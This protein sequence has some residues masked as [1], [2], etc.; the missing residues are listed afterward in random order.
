[1][2]KRL[3]Y[4]FLMLFVIL[5]G[6]MRA[7]ALEQDVNGVYQIGTAQDLIDFAAVV[8]DGEFGANAV[9]TTDIALSE[10]W[11]TP[12]GGGTGNAAPG[13]TAYT[14]IFDGQGHSITGFNAEGN[15]HLGLFGDANGATIKN[16]SISGTL[17]QTGGYGGGVVAWPAN[18][19]IENVHSALVINVP[20]GSTH[21]VGGVVGSARGGNTISGCT[22]S[23]SMIVAAS[24]TDNF[25][26]VVAYLGGDSVVFCANYG[27]ITFDDSGCAAGG[28]A[29]Y[30]NN[31]D[32]YVMGCLNMG[33]VVYNDLDAT[34]ATPKWGGAIVGRLRNHDLNKVKNNIW[35]EGSAT[36]AGKDNDG[37]VNLT[38]ALCVTQEQFA[39]GELCYFLNGDQSAIGWYQT[40]GT[41][42]IPV[43]DA[44]HAQV[45]MNGRLHCNG[46][47]Y[48]GAT[49]SNQ[50]TDII[51]DEHDFVDG[52]CS[53][54]GFFNESFLIPNADGYYE[55]ANARQLVWFEQLV[56]NGKVDANAVLKADI[57]F[58]DL[59]TEEEKEDPEQAEIAWTPIGDWHTGAVSSA[60]QGHF[61]GQGHTI[62]HFNVTSTQNY[63]GVFGVVST[64]S[65][66]ENFD[67]YGT[68][69]LGHKTGAVVAYT[70]D[71]TC[72]I[73]NIH[74]YMTLNIT[75]ATVTAERP[76]GIVGS[77]VN[78]TTI[79]ENCT[80][81]GILNVGGHTGN[82]G[83]I[84]GYINNN[85]AAIVNITNCLFD[86]EIQNG[87]SADGQCG[88]IVG[89]NNGG[90]AT[91]KNCLSVGTIVSSEG[92]IG[93]LI[94]RLNGSNTVFANNYYVGEFVNGTK[95]GKSAGGTAPVNVDNGQLASGEICWKLNEETFID[96]VWHQT[97]GENDYP[98]LN[99]N[100]AI[101]YQTPSG[102][103]CVSEKNPDSFDSFRD[104]IIDKETDFI[105]D[106]NMVAY[107][108][109][110]DEYKETIKSWEEID[111]YDDF[112]AAYK[113]I[114]ELKERVMTSAASYAAYV[115]ACEYAVTYLEENNVEGEWATLLQTYLQEDNSVEPDNDYPN[116]SYA[117]IMENR[118]LD[119]DAI[120]A[121]IAFVNQM[122]ENAIAGGITAGTEITRLLANSTFTQGEDNFEGWSKE[123]DGTIAF[124]TGG[125]TELMPL[126]RALGNGT[127]NISQTLTELPNGIYM[128]A[129]NGLFRS[130][131]DVTHQF[132]AGQLYL[133]GTANYF[134]SPGEDVVLEEDAVPGENCL[135]EGSDA[136]FNDKDGYMIG[137][138]PKSLK[139]CSY[140]YKAG[141]YQ[142]FCATEVTDGNLTVGVRSLG[143]GLAS[144]W[145]PF[146]NLHVYY[147]GTAEEANEKL[148]D[149]LEAFAA[150]AQVIVDFECS[151][152][153]DFIEQKPN[154]STELK[155]QLEE[156]IAGVEGATTGEEKMALIN[157]FSALFNEV[158]ACRKAYIAMATPCGTTA[159]LIGNLAGLGYLSDD[160]YNEMEDFIYATLDHF[161][162]GDVTTEEALAIAERLN[163]IM[164]QI[165][166][167]VD[168]V[169]QLA[170]PEQLQLFSVLINNGLG[171]AKAVL[172]NDIDMS[173]LE[174][175]DPIGSGENPFSGEFDG[176][177][178]K[179]TGFGK[180]DEENGYTLQL[181]GDKQGFF[182][183]VKNAT[184][185]NFSIEGAFEYN[186][187]TGI[188]L[189]GWAEGT[190]VRNV[191]SNL[192]IAVPVTSHH[193][194]GICG[195]FRDSSKA[196]NCS[197]SGKITVTDSNTHDC[198]GG[199]GGYSNGGCLYE[200]CANY[201]DIYYT[202]ASCYAG[203]IL[204]YINTTSL[205]GVKN[206][207]SVGT[208][209]IMSGTPTNGGA[210]IGTARNVDNST[211][212]NN[213][214]LEGSAHQVS[215]ENVV[216]ATTVTAEQL[217]SG[218]VCYKLNGDQT[219]INWFQTLGEDAYPVLDPT[220][221]TVL[222]DEQSDYHNEADDEDGI[223]IIEHSTLNIEHSIYNLSG[224]RMSRMQKGIN[225]VG[226]KKIL[227]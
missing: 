113:A 28:V 174:N 144:D 172:T 73:R 51:Q 224:Q 57:D 53:Y 22:F 49:Y 139:G 114:A 151:D 42:A 98:V 102:Y 106:E 8:N 206:C 15:V 217:A 108:G 84:V 148:A 1:M 133:N 5:T 163:H 190:T 80:Y 83:G 117:Y 189:I 175:F 92:N 219:V 40:L 134:M 170:T 149:V 26:G 25:A 63:Y 169:F 69:N 142:N 115:Q 138:V 124:T 186:G 221:K 109:L 89:Y 107:Q 72:T 155:T 59:M 200:Y 34:G 94:G 177:N 67:I 58:A 4:G 91:I 145:L 162:A 130:G 222:F 55:I 188:G 209:K 182:G 50:N 210:I 168:G 164:D 185:Q 157:T 136:N 180:Y 74:S 79:V 70:R 156:A 66:I 104:G 60:Y 197:F 165:L 137:Y 176:Q 46:D 166:P 61:D 141:R 116:G 121:E 75:E 132:Y 90:T 208:I 195:D 183:Y 48:E 128:M 218:E 78:G 158:H 213:Y 38:T 143:T 120:T 199:I 214:W 173:E 35:L 171:N 88:G 36:G 86:G 54:C 100:E 20:N 32:T 77:A 13:A 10:V 147:L 30:L 2:R 97:L 41:D 178:N 56:N 14:G 211:V 126:A 227:Y 193:I 17:T 205:A 87:D 47:V 6:S 62:K 7:W 225:I 196:Y 111:N 81:S 21:H 43:L 82:I 167:S 203:G 31:T 71:A 103:S 23:G 118:N 110:V 122:L 11:E 202:K 44:T 204:G 140:A 135:G 131:A 112:I 160:E 85:A 146:G 93:Q 181:S 223:S 201:G 105:E 191:H 9:L 212:V 27:A 68:L 129:A 207:L 125:E 192:D 187:G 99:A 198:V 65:F 179:I 153:Y 216:P 150:R 29:G 96:V 194:G 184:I 123:S 18:T 95:S 39:N 215:G 159:D 33:A 37:N 12:I 3:L 24:N 45:Y 19:T 101:V 154:I 220:H 64:G 152:G 76:G 52:I 119:D 226:G 16:F 127:F 161:T